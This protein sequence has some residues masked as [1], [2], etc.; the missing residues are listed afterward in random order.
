MS[1][2][3]HQ[4]Y[5]NTV[6]TQYVFVILVLLA[7]ASVVT[8]HVYIRRIKFYSCEFFRLRFHSLQIFYL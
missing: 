1:T 7:S 8:D 3:R 6:Y 5:L 2:V 4:E